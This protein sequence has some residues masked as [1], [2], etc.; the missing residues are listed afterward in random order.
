MSDP[1]KATEW[2]LLIIPA[3]LALVG[4]AAIAALIVF[5]LRGISARQEC[6]ESGHRIVHDEQHDEWWCA[7]ITPEK[8]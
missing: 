6:R 3:I 7:P 4:I 5:G 2:A 1:E 8:P